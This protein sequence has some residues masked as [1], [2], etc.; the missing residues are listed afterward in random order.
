MLVITCFGLNLATQAMNGVS[1]CSICLIQDGPR[2]II[3][4]TEKKSARLPK[5]MAQH[6]KAIGLS[7][8]T[9]RVHAALPQF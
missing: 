5:P 6:T 8:C 9:L 4:L 1:G 2:K 7:T 3:N